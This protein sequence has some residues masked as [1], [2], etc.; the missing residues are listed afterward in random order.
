MCEA[1]ELSDK[2]HMVRFKKKKKDHMVRDSLWVGTTFQ[3]AGGFMGM[4]AGSVFADEDGA[5]EVSL[6]QLTTL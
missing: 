1:G 4:E 3:A 6:S 2:D 5:S